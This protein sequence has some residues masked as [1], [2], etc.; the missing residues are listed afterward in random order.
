MGY[1]K[2]ITVYDDSMQIF[3]S[4]NIL[5]KYNIAA[6]P[7]VY[8]CNEKP[9]YDG[10]NAVA[11]EFIRQK[12][13]FAVSGPMIPEKVFH[14]AFQQA[15]NEGYFSVIVVCPHGKWYPYYKQAVSAANKFRRSNRF[16]FDTFSIDVIDSKSFASGVCLH[17]LSMAQQY[18]LCHYPAETVVEYGKN[19]ALKNKTYILLNTE[20][21]FGE[22]CGGL[23]AF[24]S[25]GYKF[26]KLSVSDSQDCVKLDLFADAVCKQLKADSTRYSVS[27]GD[28][29]DFAGGVIGRIESKSGKKP[30]SVNCYSIASADVLSNSAF[31]VNLFN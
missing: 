30:V 21:A 24:R 18:E 28:G 4:E 6:Y 26:E 16:D 13:E 19:L 1:I 27:F 3:L 20:S 15:Y 14:N 2:F 31:C 10:L 5:K 22:K 12:S 25:A 8:F 7:P 11:S 23:T 29:C 9:Y 17:T